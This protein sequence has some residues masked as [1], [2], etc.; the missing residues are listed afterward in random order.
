MLENP[1]NQFITSENARI[2]HINPLCKLYPV[3]S[4]NDVFLISKEVYDFFERVQDFPSIYL[5]LLVVSLIFTTNPKKVAFKQG[6][7]IYNR[8]RSGGNATSAFDDSLLFI[9]SFLSPSKKCSYQFDIT[10]W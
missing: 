2:I 4:T 7:R 1:F 8:F 10:G 3:R 9:F 6:L 5:Q